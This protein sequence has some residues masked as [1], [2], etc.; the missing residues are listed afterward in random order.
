MQTLF[1]LVVMALTLWG[2]IAL[3]EMV[4]KAI[5]S[6]RHPETKTEP[7]KYDGWVEAVGEGLTGVGDSPESVE[8]M[9]GG[10]F[11]RFLEHL[12]HLFHH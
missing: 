7:L 6:A 9:L 4:M 12:G 1:L 2:A 5:H 10:F 8:P 3:G 11:G